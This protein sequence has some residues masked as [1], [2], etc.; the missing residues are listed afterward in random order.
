[1]KNCPTCEGDKIHKKDCE[2]AVDWRLGSI[3]SEKNKDVPIWKLAK[4]SS[5]KQAMKYIQNYFYAYSEK[6]TK[7]QINIR[8]E[9][10]NT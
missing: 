9:N 8:H 7:K 2:A 6:L 5:E 10:A 4:F 3:V 1:M